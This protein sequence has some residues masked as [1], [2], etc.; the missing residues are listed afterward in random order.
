ML[1]TDLNMPLY[2][3]TILKIKITVTGVE[4]TDNDSVMSGN[5]E[6]DE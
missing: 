1:W 3:R 2:G 5:G 4:T 6:S